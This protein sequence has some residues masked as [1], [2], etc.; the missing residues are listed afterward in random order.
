V[1]ERMEEEMTM[2][3]MMANGKTAMRRTGWE[4]KRKKITSSDAD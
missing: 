1:R 4:K 3:M 2:M